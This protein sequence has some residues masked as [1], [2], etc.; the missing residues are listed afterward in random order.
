M[1]FWILLIPL[2]LCDAALLLLHALMILENKK[3][4]DGQDR[5]P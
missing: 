3:G 5:D 4:H 1:W 2:A